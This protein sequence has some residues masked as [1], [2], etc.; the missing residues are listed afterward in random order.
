MNTKMQKG[1]TLIELMIVV[2]IIG[3]LAAV[4]LPAYKDYIK[5]A[6]MTKV[7]TQYEEALRQVRTTYTKGHTLI[8]L[9][10]TDSKI[11]A[12][13]NAWI[14]LFNPDNRK[15]PGGTPAF[16]ATANDVTGSIGI[17]IS[18]SNLTQSATITLPAYEDLTPPGT[19][20]TISAADQ[21]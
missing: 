5:T 12:S 2:A 1:F 19:P 3:I 14:A 20:I 7:K 21:V 6:N 17:T 10:L 8:A 16:E 18:G 15:S 9:G 11:P 4:A 13:A